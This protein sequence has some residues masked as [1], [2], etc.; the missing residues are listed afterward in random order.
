MD[1]NFKILTEDFFEQ[2]KAILTDSFADDPY[3]NRICGNQKKPKCLEDIFDIGLR[4]CYKNGF[5]YGCFSGESLVGVS[6]WF[7]FKKILSENPEDLK[8]I[9]E[10]SSEIA[11]TESL[12]E[13]TIGRLIGNSYAC[14]YLLSVAV[15]PGF[16]GKGVASQMIENVKDCYS[17]YDI[18]TD[19]SNS[20]WA[21]H[22]VAN[23]GFSKESSLGGCDLLFYRSTQNAEIS[24]LLAEDNIPLG[25]PV[26]VDLTY[27]FPGVTCERGKAPFV[28]GGIASEPFFTQNLNGGPMDINIVYVSGSWLYKWQQMVNPLLSEEVLLKTDRGYVISY[29]RQAK[30]RRPYLSYDNDLIRQ[31]EEHSEEWDCITDIYTLVPVEYSP[32]DSVLNPN[33]NDIN[34]TSLLIDS[35]NFRTKYESGVL[36]G[37]QTSNTFYNRIER[38]VIEIVDL[39]LYEELSYNMGTKQ[40][41]IGQPVSAALVLSKDLFTR[42]GVL[43]I[44]LLSCGLFPTQYL[45]SVSRNQLYIIEREGADKTKRNIYEYLQEK[46]GIYKRGKAKNFINVHKPRK[47]LDNALLA[48]MLYGET[49]YNEDEGLSNVIDPEILEITGSYYGKAQY[50]YASAFFYTNSL[51]QVYDGFSSVY[52]RVVTQS[53][54][55]FYVEII[56]FEESAIGIMNH[57]V[58]HFLTAID[59][60]SHHS[61]IKKINMLYNENLKTI[62]FWNV[63]VNYPS[64]NKSIDNIRDAFKIEALRDELERNKQQLVSVSELR[65]NYLSYWEGRIISVLGVFLTVISITEFI[66]D[67]SKNHSL[68]YIGICSLLLWIILLKKLSPNPRK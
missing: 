32:G 15:T 5:V 46:Y 7:D 10:D 52:D 1:F 68:I 23:A 43:H 55:L 49:Y 12:N 67:P 45:D 53:L 8:E 34:Q 65:E 16:Q 57:E 25:V 40:A 6:L 2:A 63:T 54:A 3:F 14:L 41:E 22:L 39:C 9:F 4:F 59:S 42:C 64:S 48:S 37:E 18:F 61:L 27:I 66:I 33:R 20:S 17:Q 29:V 51:I 58:E 26:G 50:K 31:V 24:R 28:S 21:K 36:I 47:D 35:L 11:D 38:E 30:D 60:F 62:A 19:V 13:K 56:L 44:I